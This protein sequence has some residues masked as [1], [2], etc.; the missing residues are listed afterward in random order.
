MK[1]IIIAVG[2]LLCLVG[3]SNSESNIIEELDNKINSVDSYNMSGTLEIYRNEDKYTY[4][5]ESSYSK[6][7]L[8]KVKLLNKNNNHEQIILKN[9][10]GVYVLTPS[11]NKSFKFQSEW[12]YNNSQIY[13]LQPIVSDLMNDKDVKIEKTNDGYTITSKVNYTT[14]KD[15][16]NQKVYLDKDINIKIVEVLDSNGNVRMKLTVSNLNYNPVFNNDYFDAKKY[17]NDEPNAEESKTT[18]KLEDVVYP[19]YIPTDTYLSNQDKVSTENGE[20]VILTFSGEESFT[21][22]QETSNEIGTTN[23]IYGDPY[24][25]LD[26]VGSI[27]DSSVSWISNGVEYSVI[28]D[29]M[30]VSEII[31]VAQSISLEATV[32]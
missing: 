22:I 18:A 27:T 19:L 30:P 7:D 16:V 8:Y 9:E 14:E 25:I 10:E 4:D 5:V 12:P 1:K 2:L 32:K 11:L 23:Y 21:V 24:L 3:C 15:F 28:S 17:I 31:T 20:R 29:S 6:S 13:L 26:T